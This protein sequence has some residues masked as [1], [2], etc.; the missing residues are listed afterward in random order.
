LLLGQA[1]QVT[2]GLLIGGFDDDVGQAAGY[3]RT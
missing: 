2:A 1:G 3:I